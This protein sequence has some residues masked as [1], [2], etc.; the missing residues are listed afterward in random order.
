MIKGVVSFLTRD[1]DKAPVSVQKIEDLVFDWRLYPRKQIDQQVV[2]NY[3]RA[4]RAGSVFPSVKVGLFNGRKILVDGVHRVSSRKLLK[5]GYVDC[6]I[7]PFH[8]EAELFAEAV[9]LNSSHGKAFCEIE[10]KE[11]IKRLQKYKFDT[12]DIVAIC[13][14]P[15]SEIT[16]ETAR[17]I[18]SVTLPNGRKVSCTDV[19]PGE[20]GV[21]GLIC[22]KNALII[23]SNWSESGKIPDEPPFRELVTRARVALGKVRF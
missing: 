23:V 17:P 14:L 7:L 21:H 1:W 10:L 12:N 6:S 19:K 18:T 15:A 11:N 9:R 16:R 20:H 22:L 3:A 5:I 4:L 2:E 13:H 8:S